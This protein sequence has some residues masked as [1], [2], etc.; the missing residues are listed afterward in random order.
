LGGALAQA[1]GLEEV[2]SVLL[3]GIEVIQHD[4]H[5]FTGQQQGE[6]VSGPILLR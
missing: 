1:E 5:Q 3:P 2:L 6:V 4:L